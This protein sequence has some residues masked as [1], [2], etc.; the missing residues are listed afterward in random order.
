MAAMAAALWN[1]D[2]RHLAAAINRIRMW[3]YAES[4]ENWNFCTKPITEDISCSTIKL[5]YI[6]Q[7][8][9]ARGT[10]RFPSITGLLQ[11]TKILVLV[12]NLRKSLLCVFFESG[13]L[14]SLPAYYKPLSSTGIAYTH[15]TGI[16]GKQRHR[17]RE[18]HTCMHVFSYF[19]GAKSLTCIV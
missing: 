12:E 16:M 3:E 15:Q 19:S 7:P 4:K 17:Q 5:P 6:N 13:L 14:L 18:R 9:S 2:S 8:V 1:P 10:A 11:N